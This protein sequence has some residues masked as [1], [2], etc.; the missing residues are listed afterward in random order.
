MTQG[1]YFYTS[2]KFYNEIV[3]WY[4]CVWSVANQGQRFQETDV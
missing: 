4:A 3:V 1:A 2:W